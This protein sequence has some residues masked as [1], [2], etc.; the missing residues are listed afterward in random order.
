M[1]AKVKRIIDMDNKEK[2]NYRYIHSW[3]DKNFEKL[4][5]CE[6]CGT[7][8]KKRYEWALK[9]NYIYEYKRNNF[10]ILC[11]SC[12]RKYDET[13]FSRKNKSI[14]KKGKPAHNK[15]AI[16]KCDLK[17]HE[18]IEKY[19]SIIEASQNNKILRTSILNNLSGLSKQAGGYLWKRT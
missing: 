4:N 15:I 11:V 16:N 18:V 7:T 9:K 5:K 2:L 10:F 1:T 13:E 17:T 6:L 8:D 19:S 14:S 12:H 3:L